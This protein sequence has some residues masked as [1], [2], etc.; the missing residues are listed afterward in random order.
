MKV[1]AVDQGWAA[2]I[3][4][5]VGAATT[6]GTAWAST[7]LHR[8]QIRREDYLAFL[9]ATTRVEVAHAK[10]VARFANERWPLDTPLD[11]AEIDQYIVDL[12]SA[13]STVRQT[14]PRVYLA[15]VRRVMGHASYVYAAVLLVEALAE[16]C[17]REHMT[18]ALP[19]VLKADYRKASR[20]L[21]KGMYGFARAARGK[22]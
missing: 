2:I 1:G 19:G 18:S 14:L 15:G 8:R 11:A 4:A 7:K 20:D 3:G 13:V 12:K 17:R 16:M 6:G 9:D 10:L 22:V 5:A 21:E